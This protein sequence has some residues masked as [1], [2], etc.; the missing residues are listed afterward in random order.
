MD[1]FAQQ[2]FIK[3]VEKH[4]NGEYEAAFLGYQDLLLQ[5]PNS[6]EVHHILGIYHAQSDQLE[7]ALHHL[8]TAHHLKPDDIRIEQALAT[9]EKQMGNLSQSIKRLLKITQS[10]PNQVTSHINLAASFI[11]NNEQKKAD[12]ILDKLLEQDPKI[13]NIYFH[14]ALIDLHH[15]SNGS[16]VVWLEKTLE[17]EPDHLPAIKQMAKTLHLMGQNHSAKPHYEK[18]LRYDPNDAE[19]KHYSGVNLLALDDQ[20]T[21][22]LHMLEA[23]ALDP[24]LEDINHNLAAIY[25]TQ[26]QFKSAVYHWLRE[27]QKSPTADTFYNIG[28]SYQYLN[29]LDDARHYLQETLKIDCEH[30]GALINLGANALQCFDHPLAIG[31]YQRALKQSPNDQ[32]I[33]HVLNALQG[34]QQNQ[35]PSEYIQGLFDQYANHYDDHLI[36]VLDYQVPT[37]MLRMINEYTGRE[38]LNILDAGCGTG[39]MGERLKPFTSHLVGIDLSEKMIEKAREKHIYDALIHGNITDIQ[40]EA[41]DVIIL[42][43]VMPYVGDP[44]DLF[45]WAF[46]QLKSHGLLC[47]SFENSEEPNWHLQKTARFC[48]NSA[49]VTQRLVRHHFQIQETLSC[50][51]RKQLGVSLSGQIIAATKLS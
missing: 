3:L 23:Y 22:L 38:K 17:L 13:A 50:K 1:K 41:F 39:L 30:L 2:T 18:A 31:Y 19:L 32:S 11:K 42:A 20:D 24:S 48:H 44:S 5:Y 43:D 37:L 21:A 25:L 46:S 40:N 28:V 6:H 47:L 10:H 49:F 4:Q 8:Q 34:N 29:R 16:A 36:K 26:G 7:Q 45:Q 27:H 12:L 9:L 14:K 15:N 35:T 33:L 51:L